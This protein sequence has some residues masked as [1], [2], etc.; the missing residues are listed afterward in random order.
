MSITPGSSAEAPSTEGLIQG[1]ESKHHG[2][3]ISCSDNNLDK[4]GNII[5][6]L[7]DQRVSGV[8][9]EPATSSETPAYNEENMAGASNE[10]VLKPVGFRELFRK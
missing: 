5:L 7:I 4:Q 9:L 3:M 1:A 6:R 10:L 8:V 2:M